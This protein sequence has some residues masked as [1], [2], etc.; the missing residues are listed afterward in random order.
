M[1]LKKT[2][3][4]SSRFCN[5]SLILVAFNEVRSDNWMRNTRTFK[6]IL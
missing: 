4:E 2:P 3:L 1:F 6:Y 5:V